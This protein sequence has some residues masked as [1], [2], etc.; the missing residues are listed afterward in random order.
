MKTV[1]SAMLVSCF[2]FALAVT[3]TVSTPQNALAI[4]CCYTCPPGC[5]GLGDGGVWKVIPQ[6]HIYYC[7]EAREPWEKCYYL[8]NCECP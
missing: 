4:Q 7:D 2:I 1:V 8:G 3:L 5:Q 6:T